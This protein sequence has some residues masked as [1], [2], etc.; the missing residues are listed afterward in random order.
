MFCHAY[1]LLAHVAPALTHMAAS[2]FQVGEFM[3]IPI[4]GWLLFALT[5]FLLLT[6]VIIVALDWRSAEEPMENEDE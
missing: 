6:F 3:N 2:P 4:W 1:Q 5:G